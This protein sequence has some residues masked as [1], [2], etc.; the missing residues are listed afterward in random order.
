M[1][2]YKMSKLIRYGHAQQ[3]VGKHNMK[4]RCNGL[5]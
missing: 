2:V 1:K 4:S 3:V 5:C